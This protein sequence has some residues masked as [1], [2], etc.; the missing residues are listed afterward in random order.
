M[1]HEERVICGSFR[2]SGRVG[3]HPIDNLRRVHFDRPG[4][5]LD[6]ECS[7]W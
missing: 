7:R 3:G 5:R 6:P 4:T 2:N 1:D